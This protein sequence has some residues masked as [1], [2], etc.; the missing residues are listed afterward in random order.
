MKG[1][2]LGA[3]KLT[4]NHLKFLK[5]SVRNIKTV[6]TITR[7]SKYL[8]KKMIEPIDFQKA[9]VIIE[10]GAGDGVVTEQILARMSPDCRLLTFEVNE[11]F[12]EKLVAINDDRMILIQ[13][14]AEKIDA[15]C[16]EHDIN[17]VDYIISAIP[18][19]VFSDNLTN[20]ILDQCFNALKLGG[21]FVQIHYSLIRKKTYENVFGNVKLKF[22]PINIPPAW[23]MTS[24]KK[25]Y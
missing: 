22:V 12:C 3:E 14:S 1:V 19:V 17:H 5:E 25:P 13:D 16:K 21:K 6:G 2:N 24:T 18:F 20:S 8:C 7:S 15:Y 11:K 23:V 4:M 9:K 10:L